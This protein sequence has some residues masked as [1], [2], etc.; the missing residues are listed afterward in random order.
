MKFFA[1]DA[2]HPKSIEDPD[3]SPLMAESFSELPPAF[4]QVA[5]AD[6]LRDDG[7]L[8]EQYLREGGV[9][10]QLKVSVFR[11]CYGC[12]DHEFWLIVSSLTIIVIRV[13]VTDSQNLRHRLKLALNGERISMK[14]FAGFSVEAVFKLEKTSKAGVSLRPAM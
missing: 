2:Y 12:L 9:S 1:V 10:T 11:F 3:V 6:L 4:V 8:Y 13:L 14:E 5:G 7:L